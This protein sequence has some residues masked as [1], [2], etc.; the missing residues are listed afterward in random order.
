MNLGSMTKFGISYPKYICQNVHVF[1]TSPKYSLYTILA[2][3]KL[4]V[5]RKR[6]WDACV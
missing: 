4:R 2:K 6:Q 3:I 5:W 1:S